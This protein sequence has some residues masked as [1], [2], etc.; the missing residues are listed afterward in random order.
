MKMTNKL[1]L[2]ALLVAPMLFSGTVLAAGEMTFKGKLIEPPNCTINTGKPIDV[3]FGNEVMTSRVD[4]KLYSK[5]ITHGLK[6]EKPE[7]KAMKLQIKGSGASIDSKSLK[8]SNDNLAI[9]LQANGKK[10]MLNEWLNFDY[11]DEGSVPKLTAV[12]VKNK[13]KAL[14]GGTFNATATLLVDYK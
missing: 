6:C 9:E 1:T 5:T 7:L 14:T 13:D 8:T 2:A 3:D 4:G 11:T 10:L 12:P